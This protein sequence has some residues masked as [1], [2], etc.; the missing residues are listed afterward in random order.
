[1]GL[2]GHAIIGI[3]EGAHQI[4]ALHALDNGINELAHALDRGLIADGSG[5]S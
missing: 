1:M 4:F 3:G 5:Q 2:A